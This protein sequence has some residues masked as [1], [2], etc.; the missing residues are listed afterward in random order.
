MKMAV[1]VDNQYMWHKE[2]GRCNIVFRAISWVLHYVSDISL[3]ARK[4]DGAD[5]YKGSPMQPRQC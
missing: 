1:V 4:Q 2:K 3:A 5:I